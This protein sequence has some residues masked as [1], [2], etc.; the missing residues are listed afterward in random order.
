MVMD[1]IEFNIIIQKL[2]EKEF[3][4]FNSEQYGFTNT[5]NNSITRI[6]YCTKFYM[7]WRKHVAKN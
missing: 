1:L 6:G 7:E 4:Q 5:T 2:F 3:K